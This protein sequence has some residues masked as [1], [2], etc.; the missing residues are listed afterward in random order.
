L[1]KNGKLFKKKKIRR[2]VFAKNVKEINEF[3]ELAERDNISFRLDVNQFTEY[4]YEEF[5]SLFTGLKADK[6]D[7]NELNDEALKNRQVLIEKVLHDPAPSYKSTEICTD[8]YKE[9]A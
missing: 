5:V 9:E 2:E 4:E 8:L 1:N 3:N 6:N 7:T